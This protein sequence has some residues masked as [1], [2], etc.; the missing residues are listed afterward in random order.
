[1][2]WH[3]K[4]P[5]VHR[6][7]FK[8]ALFVILTILVIFGSYSIYQL[9]HHRDELIQNQ[10]ESSQL[11]GRALTTSLEIAMINKDIAGIQ[12]SF[13]DITEN[14][15]VLRVFL[16]NR[17]K[18]VRAA[19]V[20]A[21]VGAV[22]QMEDS[23]CKECHGLPESQNMPNSVTINNGDVLRVVIPI[24]NQPVCHRCHDSENR[25]NGLLVLD[26]SLT[27]VKA[28]LYAGIRRA[29]LLAVIS[30]LTM[31][32]LLR[33]YIKRMVINRVAYIESLARHVVNNDLD[34]DIQLS[35]QDELASL[36][37]SLD[38]MKT[39]LRLSI[40]K[41]ENH[42]NYLT[43][44]LNSL[45]EG[46][47]IVDDKDCIAYVNGS[48]ARIIDRES[49][50]IRPGDRVDDIIPPDGSFSP[51]LHQI[52]Q[53]RQDKNIPKE[54][55]RSRS[56]DGKESY[57]EVHAGSLRL[58]PRRKSEVIVV[59]R[60]V[61]TIMLSEKQVHQ[62]EKLATVGRLAAGVAHEIN[63]PMAS[64][65]TCAEGLLAETYDKYGR[66]AEYLTII[67]D[68]AQRC[69]YITQKLLDYSS[70]SDLKK[71]PV[72]IKE[73][74]EKAVSLLQF[75][76]SKKNVSISLDVSD[77]LPM[78]SASKDQLTQVFVNLILNGIQAVEM[79]GAVEVRAACG[80]NDL[81]IWVHDDGTGISEASL[82]YIFEPFFT[83][84]SVGTGTGLGLSVSHGIVAQHRGRL[85]ITESRKG[86]TSVKVTLPL[87]SG[88]G[89]LGHD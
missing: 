29:A 35:G 63:N 57:F 26:R 87:E 51:I 74:L 61:T 78:I 21:A 6:L 71:E 20:R 27:P 89:G 54:I 50:P 84:K 65:M 10:N 81:C 67:K 77:D 55:I 85:E 83:T 44:L 24:K 53:A 17:N 13:E 25:I 58:P 1:M 42:R 16:L 14:D 40:E 3:T 48:L 41:I 62:S 11:L 72:S 75:E 70:V 37:R 43:N 22:W 82:P 15:N 18:Q 66:N 7:H 80:D 49:V 79:G 9:L 31:M 76:A 33:W 36:S 69:K 4:I 8:I 60:D 56:E 38:N 68:A 28:E 34:L 47:L 46:I 52:R 23:G 59:V 2:Q 88:N 12:R 5:L 32:F 64:I 30:V 39:T 73:V 45:A 19:S 86:R